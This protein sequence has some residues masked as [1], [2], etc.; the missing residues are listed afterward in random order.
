MPTQFHAYA[1]LTELVARYRTEAR[2]VADPRERDRLMD[3]ADATLDE[4]RRLRSAVVI[5]DDHQG[6]L[7][8]ENA[9]ASPLRRARGF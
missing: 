1:R 9:P 8:L 2:T 6:Q 5:P 4:A 7:E 3:L